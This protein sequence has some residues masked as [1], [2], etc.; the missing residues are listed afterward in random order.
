MDKYRIYLS[1]KDGVESKEVFIDNLEKLSD[2]LEEQ[3][4]LSGGIFVNAQVWDWSIYKP[5]DSYVYKEGGWE[6]RKIRYPSVFS[7]K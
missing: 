7:R 2:V 5:L 1:A 4:T 3:H 6:K